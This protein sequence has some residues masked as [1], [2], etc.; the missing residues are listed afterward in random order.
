MKLSVR[1]KLLGTCGTLLVLLAVTA[2]IGVYELATSNDRLDRIVSGPA[3]AARLAAQLRGAAAKSTRAQRDLMLAGNAAERDAAIAA[4]EG[5]HQEHVELRRQL[6]AVAG[7]SAGKL[8]ELDVAWQDSVATE[9]EIRAAKLRA[10]TERAT[11]LALD[12][13]RKQTAA[14]DGALE[15]L[16]T[17][18]IRR[19]VPTV[20]L[21]QL[22]SAARDL[23][24]I[25]LHEA[26]VILAVDDKT[27][28]AELSSAAAA[29]RALRD[30]VEEIARTVTTPD[31]H[32]TL[33]KLRSALAAWAEVHKQIRVLGR[34]NADVE[35]TRLALTKY[36][37]IVNRGAKIAD[38]I[39]AD[40]I[41]ALAAAQLASQNSY[42]TSRAILIGALVVAILLGVTLTLTIVRY[43]GSAL[44]A[45]SQLANSVAGGDL[46]Q[47]LEVTH[48]DEIGALVT[49]LNDMVDN[50]R[51][52]ATE[53]TGAAGQVTSSASSV[54][55]AAEEMSAT[56]GQVAEG[57]T[58]Q[59][60][61]T[62]ETTAAMEQMAAS[63]QQNS[64]NA[65]TTDRLASKASTDAQSSGEAVS[66]TLS[67]MKTIADRI[68]IIEEIARKTDLLALNAAVEAARAAEHGRGFAVVASE[69]RKL[70]ERS[71]TAAAEISE[72]AKRGVGLAESAGGMLT[73]LLPDIRKTAELVQEVSAASREQ[74]TGI[75]QSNK[76][77]QDLD[78]VTQQNAAAAEE[79]AS[80]AGG[81]AATA[82][83]L[84]GHAEQLQTAVQFFKLAP[85]MRPHAIA[86][87]AAPAPRP[88]RV[89]KTVQPRPPRARAPLVKPSTSNGKLPPTIDLDLG[90]PPT[91]DDHLFERH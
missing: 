75:E 11:N 40:E 78:R 83:E 88:S 5:H 6:G 67:A 55:A 47:T 20:V 46:T 80:T 71:A 42:S 29:E 7:P 32:R 48:A 62:Q 91:S 38:A 64:D 84:S 79:M 39:I 22:G 3:A 10:T 18:L 82:S 16:A 17:E 14:V 24:K 8:E 70:A 56:A 63:V 2:V 45:A 51:R 36:Q 44:R 73:R 28:D 9:K 50:L 37:P 15:A 41:G 1:A 53:V 34:E 87:T 76:A 31:E 21:R 66:D 72:L 81:M 58:Q 59:G 89:V 35:A 49:S 19:A 23:Q 74:T 4:L 27:M 43:L 52:V 90:A 57:A 54:A 33:D 65:Q 77:L 25:E 61:A 12:E 86:M 69:V 13:G 26:L 85:G 30:S 68:G 60:A